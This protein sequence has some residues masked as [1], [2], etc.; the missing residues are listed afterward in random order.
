MFLAH[1]VQPH[2]NMPMVYSCQ[3]LPRFYLYANEFPKHIWFMDNQIPQATIGGRDLNVGI[4]I[5]QDIQAILNLAVKEEQK[6]K[7]F[8]EGRRISVL[9]FDLIFNLNLL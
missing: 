6:K 3:F 8:N 1:Y 7:N 4:S 2:L 5:P 9:K